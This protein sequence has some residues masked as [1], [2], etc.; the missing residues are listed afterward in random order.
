LGGNTNKNTKH[1][2]FRDWFVSF[3]ALITDTLTN[4]STIHHVGK[5][6]I[7]ASS[8]PEIAAVG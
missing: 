8:G 5:S 6:L 2:D 1:K 4:T 3:E 7:F